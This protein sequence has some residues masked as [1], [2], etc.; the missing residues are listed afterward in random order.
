MVLPIEAGPTSQLPPMGLMPFRQTQDF[1]G[2]P[3]IRQKKFAALPRCELLANNI[4]PNLL[5]F[6]LNRIDESRNIT[7][8][9]M[10]RVISSS[11]SFI[12]KFMIKPT[13]FH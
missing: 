12:V 3:K 8:V 1:A 13:G 10:K 2:D 11:F 6:N 4:S 7:N 5:T 9:I